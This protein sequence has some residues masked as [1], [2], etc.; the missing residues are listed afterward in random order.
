MLKG[1]Y[2]IILI[3]GL[4]M[5]SEGKRKLKMASNFWPKQLCGPFT[6]LKKKEG[7]NTFGEES[8]RVLFQ[9]W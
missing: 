3:D 5:G 8:P 4:E 6:E 9:P 2:I 7:R 1:G